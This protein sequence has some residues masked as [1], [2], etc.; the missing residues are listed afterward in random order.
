MTERQPT[1][2]QVMEEVA[3]HE[4]INYPET[5]DSRYVAQPF[6][7]LLFPWERDLWTT[8]LPSKRM[9]GLLVTVDGGKTRQGKARKS[10][11]ARQL[12]DLFSKSLF[13]SNY[14]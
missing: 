10:S 13:F 4:E 2:M 9:M 12:F 7:D 14:F 6:D 8:Q 3:E 1:E 5:P 11:A